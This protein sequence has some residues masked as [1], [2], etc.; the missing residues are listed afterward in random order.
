MGS[1]TVDI[2]KEQSGLRMDALLF[3]KFSP[4]SSYPYGWFE[5]NENK[6]CYLELESYKL[7]RFDYLIFFVD[8]S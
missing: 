4:L 7:K 8:C 6:W 1:Y 3:A 5:E 2:L